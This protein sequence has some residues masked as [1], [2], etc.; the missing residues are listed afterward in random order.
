MTPAQIQRLRERLGMSQREFAAA[1]DL[2]VGNVRN[3]EQGIRV[4]TGA[5]RTLL[6]IVDK[7]PKAALR[8]LAPKRRR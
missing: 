4:P 2:S 3:W 7:E 5:A 6:R 1:F 8:A